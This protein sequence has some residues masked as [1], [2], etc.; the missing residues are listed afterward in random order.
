MER[1][2]QEGDAYMLNVSATLV[3][4]SQLVIRD[5]LFA[6]GKRKYA[7][8]WSDVN[9]ELRSRWDNAPHWPSV[10]TAP[11]HRHIA[12]N[13]VPI[14]SDVTNIEDLMAF[15]E[16]WFQSQASADQG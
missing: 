8:Q 12:G 9:G 2:E 15:L 4:G 11:H 5:Y 6:D 16:D 13:V 14:S 7:Y 3:D 1:Y 10:D